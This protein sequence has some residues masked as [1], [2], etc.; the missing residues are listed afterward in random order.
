MQQNDDYSCSTRR[1]NVKDHR[2]I[3]NLSQRLVSAVVMQR[4][5]GL[6]I[7]APQPSFPNQSSVTAAV[8]N[9]HDSIQ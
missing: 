7:S 4:F 5:Q 2:A 9:P 1:I 3:Q 6:T 8:A